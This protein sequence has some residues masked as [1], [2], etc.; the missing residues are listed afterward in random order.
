MS[1]E[2]PAPAAVPSVSAPPVSAPPVSA[3]P[4]SG[5]LESA[6]PVSAPASPPLV[7][8]PPVTEPSPELSPQPASSAEIATHTTPP[9][10]L[11]C[12][13]RISSLNSLPPRTRV[14]A[15]PTPPASASYLR[16]IKKAPAPR[17]VSTAV[18]AALKAEVAGVVV[19]IG[20]GV[21]GVVGDAEQ[22]Q[23]IEDGRA[24]SPAVNQLGGAGVELTP[25]LVGPVRSR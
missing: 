25:Q 18:G 23:R 21:V 3:P 4:A 15:Q 12:F 9:T 1:P 8:V 13:Q 19:E 10:Q 24:V 14:L 11:L 5:P 6:P 2:P 20:R 7:P 22:W 17:T 16:R